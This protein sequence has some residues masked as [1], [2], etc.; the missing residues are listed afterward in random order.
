M[1]KLFIVVAKFMGFWMFYTA[2][3][4]VI[5]LVFYLSVFRDLSN[6]PNA[7]EVVG[8]F[9]F[10]AVSALFSLV[11]S[12]LLIIKTAWL[13]DKFKIDDTDN[14]PEVNAAAIL[15]TGIKLIGIYIAVFAIS[16][17]AESLGY[18]RFDF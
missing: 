17:F 8:T 4:A 16:K 15:S 6:A 5:Q 18:F 12:W 9:V 13:A 7:K 14:L 1:R 2:V 10:L 3:N 11:L